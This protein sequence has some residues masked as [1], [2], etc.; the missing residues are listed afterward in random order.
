MPVDYE[1]ELATAGSLVANLNYDYKDKY[2]SNFN[3]TNHPDG[4]TPSL[5]K[6]GGRIGFRSADEHWGVF[7][8]VKT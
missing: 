6:L 8:G 7:C 2:F 5:G 1:R 3:L 4:V